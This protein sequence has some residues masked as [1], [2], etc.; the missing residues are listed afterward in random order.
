MKTFFSLLHAKHFPG[1]GDG[2]RG[3]D[4]VLMKLE[5]PTYSISNSVFLSRFSLVA[6]VSN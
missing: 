6:K 2:G 5:K 3:Y 1:K 4:G